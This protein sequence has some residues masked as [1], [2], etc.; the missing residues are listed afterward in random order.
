MATVTETKTAPVV[1]DA[2]AVHNA[3]INERYQRLKN[4]IDEQFEEAK[5]QAVTPRAST[6]TPERPVEMPTQTVE[7]GHTR[8]DSELFTAETLDRTLQRS[9]QT[10]AAPEVEAP[11]AP[12]VAEIAPTY[13]LNMSA[14]KKAVAVFGA[15]VTV[16]LSLIGVNTQIIAATEAR[17]AGIEQKNAELVAEIA[18]LEERIAYERSEEVVAAW[19]Q[20]NGMVKGN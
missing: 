19:A 15:T 14:V 13:S 11:V 12:P 18:E 9:A 2:A 17:I 7:Y 8:V 3:G 1:T 5:A 20:E 6:L 16:M 10:Y 4:A